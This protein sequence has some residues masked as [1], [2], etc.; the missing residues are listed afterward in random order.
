M[1]IWLGIVLVVIALFLGFG[2]GYLI[3]KS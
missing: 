3:R 1:Q 2:I